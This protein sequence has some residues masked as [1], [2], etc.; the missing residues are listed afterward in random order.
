MDYKQ[1]LTT[2]YST[3][4][5]TLHSYSLN[6]STK[7]SQVTNVANLQNKSANTIVYE[8]PKT[9]VLDNNLHEILNT[10]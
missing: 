3:H 10:K 7:L 8:R 1:F 4:K 5:L 2:Y 6:N 9:F